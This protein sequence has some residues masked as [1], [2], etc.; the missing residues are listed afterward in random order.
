MTAGRKQE[1]RR[2]TT[3]V[4]R[5]NPDRILVISDLHIG[6]GHQ[7][8]GHVD[9]LEHFHEDRKLE[10]ILDR[11]QRRDERRGRR[12]ELVLNGDVFDFVRVVRLPGSR[13]E[14]AEWRALLR[15]AGVDAPEAD[16]EAAEAG[17]FSR[18]QR[19]YG[20]DCSEHASVWKLWLMARGH[21][22]V[23]EALAR[24]CAA[25][26]GLVVVRGNHDSEWAWAGVRRAF[27]VLLRAAGARALSPGQLRFRLHAYR[28]ANLWIEHGHGMRWSTRTAA[29]F[30]PGRRPRLM[31]PVGS[32]INRYVLNPLERLLERT[33]GL[34]S[35]LHLKRLAASQRWRLWRGI[36]TNAVRA[37][38]AFI[39]ASRHAW[40]QRARDW[41]PARIGGLIAA[42]VLVL[43]LVS[44]RLAG[45]LALH[46]GFARAGAAA[47]AIAG[48]QMGLALLEI[49]AAVRDGTRVQ[50]R[51]Y[52]LERAAARSRRCGRVRPLVVLGHTHAPDLQSWAGDGGDVVYANPGCWMEDPDGKAAA[53]FVWCAFRRGRYGNVRV[54]EIEGEDSRCRTHSRI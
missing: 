44:D 19:R 21:P 13:A 12:T 32:L 51:H 3:E 25:G 33:P 41:M 38:P 30:T 15:E 46:S 28:R 43:P 22:R 9:R 52:A 23:M 29:V 4:A 16:L 10:R 34:P 47:V 37:L 35:S 39:A 24:W 50:A 11:L 7:P 49:A 36:M 18:F 20:Y 27:A 31:I 5:R 54:F 17:R 14:V 2:Q 26:H 42:G 53:R 48:P 45:T 40:Y 1:E 8:D 6:A